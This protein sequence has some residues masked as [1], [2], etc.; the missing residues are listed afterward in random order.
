MN[1]PLK[2]RFIILANQEMKG[3]IERTPTTE[4][5]NKYFRECN[6]GYSGYDQSIHWCG[7][8]CTYLLRKAGANVKWVPSKGM[9]NVTG[10]ENPDGKLYITRYFGTKIGKNR[11]KNNVMVGDICVRGIG[12]HHFIA[13]GPT[14]EIGAFGHT[15]EGNYGGLANP[16]LHQGRRVENSKHVVHT[17]YRIH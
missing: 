10:K 2:H 4:E 5:L 11:Y 1:I 17:Y 13:L 15:V 12:Q 7:I 3:A 6:G 16:R 8:F 9:D 14:D